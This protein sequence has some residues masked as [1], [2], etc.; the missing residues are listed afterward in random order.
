MQFNISIGKLNLSSPF[1]LASGTWGF[2]EEL[3]NW[4][5]PSELKQCV[6]ALVTKGVSLRPMPGNPP[7]RIAETPCGFVNSIGLEN[8]GIT[9]FKE[10]HLSILLETGIPIIVNLHGE[11]V[12]EF[13]E[14]VRELKSTDVAGIELNISCPNVKK[15]GI[16][17]SSSAELVEELIKEVRSLWDKFLSV[18]L[19]PVGDVF[20]I[21]KVCERY[22]VDAIVVANTYPAMVVIDE[23]EFKFLKGGLSGPAIKPLTL[24]LVHELHQKVEI[25]IIA[26]GGIVSGRDAVDYM[27]CGAKAFQVGTVNLIDPFAVIKIFNEFKRIVED[28]GLKLWDM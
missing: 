6:G 26:C 5:S 22:E 27:L 16:S 13:S 4:V 10:K 18:K 21:A 9:A 17:F 23:G 2:G 28:R 3:F 7:P 19:S 8:P 1:M 20:N 11:S 12:E 15:G 25:P 24:R 14:L